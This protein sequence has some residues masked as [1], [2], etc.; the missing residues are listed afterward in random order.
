MEIE[1]SQIF[2]KN[3]GYH[4]ILKCCLRNHWFDE[5]IVILKGV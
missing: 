5:N 3:E 4:L 1:N 2:A